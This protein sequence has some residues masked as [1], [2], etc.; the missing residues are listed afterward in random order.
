M[1]INRD[2]LLKE[3]ILLHEAMEKLVKISRNNE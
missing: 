2:N 1:N 3:L